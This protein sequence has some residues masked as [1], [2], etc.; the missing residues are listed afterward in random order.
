ML[1]IDDS[2]LWSNNCPNLVS[3][4][5]ARMIDSDLFVFMIVY[6]DDSENN[7]LYIN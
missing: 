1:N 4:C 7:L 3:I 2:M 5:D 6:S